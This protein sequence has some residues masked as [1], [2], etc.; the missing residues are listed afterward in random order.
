LLPSA[1]PPHTRSNCQEIKGGLLPGRAIRVSSAQHGDD[2][3][4]R[5]EVA[6]LVLGLAGL[7]QG[8]AGAEGERL[9][10]ELRLAARASARARHAAAVLDAA[11]GAGEAA[12]RGLLASVDPAVQST[13]LEA[14]WL[15]GTPQLLDDADAAEARARAAGVLPAAPRSAGARAGG[16]LRAVL[17]AAL[18]GAGVSRVV[19]GRYIE[20]LRVLV[21]ALLRSVI[22]LGVR[23]SG[24]TQLSRQQGGT[25]GHAHQGTRATSLTFPAGVVLRPGQRGGRRRGRLP[26]GLRAGRAG[27]EARGVPRRR[28]RRQQRGRR[29]GRRGR[30]GANGGRRGQRRR[31]RQRRRSGRPRAG[32]LPNH[33]HGETVGLYRGGA[34]LSAVV[35]VSCA[36]S[37]SPASE[38][39]TPLPASLP[40]QAKVSRDLQILPEGAY[41]FVNAGACEDASDAVA[42]AGARLCFEAGLL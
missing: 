38:S 12:S 26:G 29:R 9:L 8:A 25:K 33:L 22:P 2:R 28:R 13:R 5:R 23:D 30:R 39:H 4:A 27:P 31:E 42:L 21:R 7:L 20:R 24:C 11:A 15:L 32:V 34:G 37:P 16:E 6:L 3:A 14:V 19:Q 1:A 36:L 10:A 35:R 17:K 41:S 40:P 18:D